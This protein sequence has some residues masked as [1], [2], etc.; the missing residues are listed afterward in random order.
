MQV[1]LMKSYFSR[2]FL[3][4]IEKEFN[5]IYTYLKIEFPKTAF[6]PRD[7]GNEA[8]E[9]ETIR[10]HDLLHDN[11]GM[12][13]GMTVRELEAALLALVAMPVQVFRK[14][15]NTWIETKMTRDWTLKQQNDRGR[16]LGPGRQE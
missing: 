16:E 11:A 2:P 15:G 1:Q 9:G 14:S 6:E 4:A 12:D 3:R 5:S 8:S 7:N 10:A 13:D